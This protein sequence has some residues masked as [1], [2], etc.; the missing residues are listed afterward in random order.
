MTLLRTD[1]VVL[2]ASA[3]AVVA[4]TLRSIPGFV[5]RLYYLEIGSD[6]FLVLMT[7]VALLSGLAQLPVREERAFWRTVACAFGAWAV[8]LTL[9]LLTPDQWWTSTFD[10][11]GDS[12]YLGFYLFLL[13]AVD[14][15]PD[16]RFEHRIHGISRRYR[17]PGTVLFSFGLFA[18]FVVVPAVLSPDMYWSWSPSLFFYLALDLYLAARLLVL[19]RVA[20]TA[21][22]RRCFALMAAVVGVF[23][24]SDSVELL[25]LRGAISADLG[26]AAL[27]MLPS[28]VI[29]AIVRL[30]A[31]PVAGT[32]SAAADS[33]W[34]AIKTLAQGAPFL[35][36]A[37]FLP[38]VHFAVYGS[39]LFDEITR[40]VHENL[41][42]VW[43]TCLGG[44]S[45]VQYLDLERK[46]DSLVDQRRLSEERLWQLAN[47][48]QLTGL[49]NRVLFHDRFSH[50]LKHAR[51]NHELLA[52]VFADLDDFKR[53]NDAYGHAAGDQLLQGVAQR[54]MRC[55]RD[56]DTVARLGGDEFTVILEGLDGADHVERLAHRI[57]SAIS[58]PFEVGDHVVTL[59]SSLGVG[60]YPRDGEDLD[61]LLA[62]AD[63]AM[64][65]G[66]RIRKTGGTNVR[67]FAHAE[68]GEWR[69]RLRL[70]TELQRAIENSEFVLFYQ[71]I[72]SVS[73]DCWIGLEALIRWR[74]PERGL[75]EPG[76]FIPMAERTGLIDSIDAWVLKSG[77]RQLESWHR[78]GLFEL[79]LA[80]N[81]SAGNFHDPELPRRIAGMLEALELEPASLEIELTETTLLDD[82]DDAARFCQ[83]LAAVGVAVSIDDFGAG[84]TSLRHLTHLSAAK[85]KIDRSLIQEAVEKPK[86]AAVVAGIVAMAHQMGLSVLAEGVETAE[87]R[88]FVQDQRCDEIQGFLLGRP[89]PP[90]EITRLMHP[91]GPQTTDAQ[92]SPLDEKVPDS[93]I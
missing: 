18:Y 10:L 26:P 17:L 43:L 64:Y 35:T 31:L 82:L 38:L 49:P 60:I 2:I 74:H 51:R 92:P 3:G 73:G 36:Y 15:R 46:H 32:E 1:R 44:L 76:A 7:I 9:Y 55:V 27:W 72:W 30:R 42:L 37:L 6:L 8:I 4:I 20:R 79:R 85:L 81:L 87:E 19:S 67:F 84:Q 50:A 47:F 41:V 88:A 68:H 91:A 57:S 56:S 71:P 89:Q 66:K 16:L 86:A 5:D 23:L 80:I 93:S 54:M 48:D 83:Q 39:G 25:Q 70:E 33:R 58:R 62:S 45:L 52:I 77:L 21:R 28:I 65:E 24:A 34:T 29:I 61:T 59:R 63:A 12:I 11:A 22:W 13:A 14:G 69:D 90:A 40:Q 75:I 53:V 78:M